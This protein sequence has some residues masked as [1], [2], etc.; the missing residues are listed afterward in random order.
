MGGGA[1]DQR[2]LTNTRKQRQ[3]RWRSKESG[4]A[5]ARDVTWRDR[6]SPT[7]RSRHVISHEPWFFLILLFRFIYFFYFGLSS[8]ETNRWVTFLPS[9]SLPFSF[10][11]LLFK[12]LKARLR[13]I[14][15]A[16]WGSSADVWWETRVSIKRRRRE[17]KKEKN[18][19]KW[20]RLNFE[21]FKT[22]P[23]ELSPWRRRRTRRGRRKRRMRMRR[24]AEGSVSSA[25]R[26]CTERRAGFL[27][28]A[29]LLSTRLLL[30][31][32]STSELSGWLFFIYVK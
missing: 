10:Q 8:S 24:S 11:T 13:L 27:F 19:W 26:R 1:T 6:H 9:L 16:S 21:M 2:R 14:S 23:A 3:E 31:R 4:N 29:L 17:K 22:L 28:T 30:N 5:E 18:T 15:R 20:R 25:A 7:A 32:S 12:S